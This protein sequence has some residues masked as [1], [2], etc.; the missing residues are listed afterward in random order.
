MSTGMQNGKK[1]T[2]NLKP[3]PPSDAE[4]LLHS[5]ET[6]LLD[7]D[8]TDNDVISYTRDWLEE[9]P[10]DELVELVLALR[11]KLQQRTT[12]IASTASW[13]PFDAPAFRDKLDPRKLNYVRLPLTADRQRKGRKAWRVIL[14]CAESDKGPIALD[15]LGD[16]FVG[17]AG[18]GIT[19][20]LDLN[21]Y[22]AETLGVSRHHALLRPTSA[23]L[24]LTDMDSTNGTY[25]DGKKMRSGDGRT[26]QSG[27]IISFGKLH[28]SVHFIEEIADGK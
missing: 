23:G 9:R 11:S 14:V 25:I 20:D 8:P 1:N 7:R 21:R 18:A 22:D 3:T 5:L 27:N 2:G 15:V 24:Q 26:L 16:A 4:K 6:R 13:V 12:R 19:P 28:F 17:R 10:R